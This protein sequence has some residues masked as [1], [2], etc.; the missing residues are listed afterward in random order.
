MRYDKL[1]RDRIPAILEAKGKRF[2]VRYVDEGYEK[3]AYLKRKLIEEVDEF[4][5]CPSIEELADVQEVVFALLDSMAYTREELEAAREVKKASR[6][7]FEDNCIL[8][9]VL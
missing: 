5:E 6:G 3:R 7:A 8:E 4:L 1:V 9:E 2:S